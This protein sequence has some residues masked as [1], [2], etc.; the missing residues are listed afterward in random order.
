M[1]RKQ[2]KTRFLQTV[3]R[4]ELAKWFDPLT[5]RR[6]GSVL[7]VGFPHVLFAQWF[8]D[9]HR[10]EFETGVHALLGPKCTISYDRAQPEPGRVVRAAKK[11]FQE[12]GRTAGTSRFDAFL[13][14]RK[15]FFPF[16]SA[17]ELAISDE[18]PYTPFVL[19][20]ES[21]TGKSF[22]L[23]IM[24]ENLTERGGGRVLLTTIR[25][26]DRLF[27]ERF[28]SLRQAEDHLAGFSSL[29]V[30]DFQDLKLFPDLHAT[31]AAG[32]S[33]AIDEGRRLVIASRD[34]IACQEYLPAGLKSR[35]EGGLIVTLAKPDLDV[36]LRFLREECRARNLSLPQDRQI[37]LA[38]RFEDFRTLKGAVL[39]IF[40]FDKLVCPEDIGRELDN[41]LTDMSDRALPELS[42]DHI[43]QT[44]AEHFDISLE[45][46]LSS[47]RKR[48]VAMAR[49]VAMYL[50]RENLRHSYPKLGRIFGGKDHTSVLYSCRKIAALQKEDPEMKRLIGTLSRKCLA[51]TT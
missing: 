47:S 48:E 21:G 14:N 27:G 25:E 46:I 5:F 11:S 20:G 6:D 2:L 28:T 19:C 32:L 3:S 26:L 23:S 50:C 30:D 37:L 12:K 10:E 4:E 8:L 42:S 33:R 16:A 34:K 35:L 1:F 39:K 17:R 18:V 36:R 40:A 43:L 9:S 29:V 44:V 15:N 38:R 31:M 22:L 45:E 13:V 24:A 7:K 51:Q 49:Q 41:I